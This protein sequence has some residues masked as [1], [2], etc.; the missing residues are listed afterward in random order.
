MNFAATGIPTSPQLP[1]SAAKP[2]ANATAG[3]ALA[4]VD[5]LSTGVAAAITSTLP[6]M[7]AGTGTPPDSSQGAT[8]PHVTTGGVITAGSTADVVASVASFTP[9]TASFGAS[10]RRPGASAATVAASYFL[11]VSAFGPV[12]VRP[13]GGAVTG[14]EVASP[15]SATATSGVAIGPPV[16]ETAVTVMN[17]LHPAATYDAATALP[18]AA[19]ISAIANPLPAVVAFD[20]GNA[21]PATQA[22][23][24]MAIPLP[25]VAAADAETV[26]LPAH[27]TN[28]ATT[29]SPA[30]AVSDTVVN[31]PAVGIATVEASGLPSPAATRS[32]DPRLTA[33]PATAVSSRVSPLAAAD[34]AI[35]RTI[36]DLTTAVVNPSSLPAAP[37]VG[38]ERK[39]AKLAAQGAN[40]SPL[41]AAVGSERTTAKL[42]APVANPSLPL[43][44]SDAI[45]ERT[46]TDVET[47]SQPADEPRS[48]GTARQDHP[49]A[50]A[51][52]ESFAVG[53]SPND[54]QPDSP[55]ALQA[56]STAF[57]A[58]EPP[59]ILASSPTPVAAKVL[60]PDAD[61][62][63]GAIPRNAPDVAPNVR[64]ASTPQPAVATTASAAPPI[65]PNDAPADIAVLPTVLAAQILSKAPVA[66]PTAPSDR[67]ASAE[68][69]AGTR[70]PSDEKDPGAADVL[71]PATAP[72]P[73]PQPVSMASVAL[74]PVQLV[75]QPQVDPTPAAPERRAASAMAPVKES[76]PRHGSRTAPGRQVK[77]S[78][79]AP[80]PGIAQPPDGVIAA[81]PFVPAALIEATPV[82]NSSTAQRAAEVTTGEIA[83]AATGVVVASPATAPSVPMPAGAHLIETAAS[84]SHNPGRVKTGDD[85][86]R[87]SGSGVSA[88]ASTPARSPAIAS[89]APDATAVPAELYAPKTSA[90]DGLALEDVSTA[91]GGLPA[92]PPP[93]VTPRPIAAALHKPQVV[94]TDMPV[95]TAQPGQIGREVGVE[96]ARRISAG[97]EEL[98]VRLD[99]AELGRIE[100]RMSFDERGG[101]H[102]VIAADSPV[103]LDMLRRDSADLS[104]SLNDAGVRSDAQ[105]LRFQNDGGGNGGQPRSP[106]LTA[107]PKSA[108][109][110]DG[111]FTDEFEG[112]P[113]RPV[114]TSGRYDLLA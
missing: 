73:Q 26:R 109:Q 76:A 8:S 106:W 67:S 21:H 13:T 97:G 39:T 108:R 18:T 80:L 45:S 58:T 54:P 7:P 70:D 82:A 1:A 31:G 36:A 46:S 81:A 102:A 86:E 65:T 103:A 10:P 78:E 61:A 68:A 38:N 43:T 27:A 55:L 44:T 92:P 29:I 90:A 56:A 114:R 63:V 99:P 37:V 104:R 85:T 47:M 4:M 50:T 9:I 96:I 79:A 71:P 28:I 35:N 6:A 12:T 66:S 101:L 113:Y 95:V 83:P 32:L 3:F 69:P 77:A 98:I 93:D 33:A 53:G 87:R 14:A 17:A 5:A 72:A 59:T 110:V 74:A 41:P 91:P 60:A 23:T 22:L 11:Q 20:A 57:A 25:Q 112:T 75:P 2:A 48:A 30:T 40:A 88:I 19:T 94:T 84:L 62:P 51:A 16:A 24:V 105:S 89:P 100:V 52:Q 15:L 49:V 111:I 107:D 42:A 64:L 34:S